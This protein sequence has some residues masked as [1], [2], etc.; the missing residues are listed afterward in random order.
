MWLIGHV[1]LFKQK[2]M[3]VKTAAE[4]TTPVVPAFEFLESKIALPLPTVIACFGSDDFLRR[5]A[6]QHV[7]AGSG[8]DSETIRSFDGETDAWRDIHDELATRSLFDEGGTKIAIVRNGDKFVS[9]SREQ[10]ERWTEQ[11]AVD[12]CLILEIQTLAANTTLYKLISKKGKLV[13]CTPPQKSSWGNPPDEKAIQKWGIAWASSKHALTLT[14]KQSALIVDRIGGVCGLI[15]CEIAKLALFADSSGKVPDKRVAELV[16]GW[17]TQTAWELSDAI[18]DGQV[19]V[20]IQQLDKL[21]T[22]GQ[23]AVGLMAQ[24]SWSL[25]RFGLAAKL[26]E[27]SERV[28]SRMGLSVALERAGFNRFDVAKAETRL[29]RIGRPRAIEMLA[30]LV[31]LELKLKGSHSND[32]RARL[33]L[34]SLIMNL[35]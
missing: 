5:T 6:I 22:A 14:E 9:K 27:Q 7:T 30:W 12:T 4:K 20:A 24:I 21:L 19:A 1:K 35:G 11:S 13:K 25:R 17:R 26:I 31:D 32:H 10:L 33:A 15:D 3:A 8:I 34:E 16:G 23:N 2:K 18:A 29:K 28:D